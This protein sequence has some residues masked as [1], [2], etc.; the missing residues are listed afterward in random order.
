MQF[1][2]HFKNGWLQPI[3]SFYLFDAALNLI[4]WLFVVDFMKLNSLPEVN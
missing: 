1:L 3:T 4:D 2:L